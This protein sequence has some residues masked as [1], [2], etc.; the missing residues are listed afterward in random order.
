MESQSASLVAILAVA[1]LVATA[2]R[3]LRLPYTVGLVLVGA[4]LV[5]FRIAPSVALTSD[6]IFYGILPPLLFEASLALRWRDLRADLLPILL[7]STIG[8]VLSAAVST[9]GMMLIL[10]W[11]LAPALLFGV[12]IAATDPVA[13]IAMFRDLGVRGRLRLLVES[14]SLF[15]DGVAAVLFAVALSVAGTHAS[16]PTAM[17]TVALTAKVVLGG[18]A[19]G[20]AVAALSIAIAGRTTEKLVE[21]ALTVVAAYGAFTLAEALHLSGVLATV[22][23]GL[24]MGN[25]GVLRER[26]EGPLSQEARTFVVEFWDFAAFLANS[27]IFPLIGIS[28]A[29]M[30]LARGDLVLIGFA[31]AV[32]LASRALTVYPLSLALLGTRRPIFWR[33]QHVLFWGG[34]RGALALALALTLPVDMPF[35]DSIVVAA[36]GVAVFSIV[37]QGLTMPLLLRALGLRPPP[38]A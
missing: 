18:L 13:V 38:S 10:H 17:A 22:T 15:N 19:I 14:E 28:V 4:L 16:P 9:A 34:L 20:A 2:A 24:V 29:S 36:F 3:R 27:V 35:R 31:I 37:V 6:L 32:V 1:M 7:L 30:A 21:T 26:D 5:V 12:L 25:V 23:A 33:E 8:T 11:P